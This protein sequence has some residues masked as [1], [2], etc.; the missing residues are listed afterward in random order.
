MRHEKLLRG[1]PMPKQVDIDIIRRDGIVR[2]L[3]VSM[4]DVFWDGTSNSRLFTT[5]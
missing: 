2:N 5:I 3:D 4:R 1:E